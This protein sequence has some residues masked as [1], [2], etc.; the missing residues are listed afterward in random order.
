MDRPSSLPWVNY[1]QL[2]KLVEFGFGQDLFWDFLCS[3]AHIRKYSEV[4]GVMMVVYSYCSLGH[5]S[6]RRSLTG[7]CTRGVTLYLSGGSFAKGPPKL[8]LK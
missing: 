3:S 7:Y 8:H 1:S 4:C 2:V 5:G 6:A